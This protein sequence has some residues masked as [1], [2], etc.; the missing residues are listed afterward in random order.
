MINSPDNGPTQGYS[1]EDKEKGGNGFVPI[2]LQYTEYTATDARETSLAGDRRTTD[3]LNRSYKGKTVIVNNSS[4]LKLVLDTRAA[5]KD[6]PVIVIIRMSNPTVVRE[7][8][9]EIDA[10]LIN[11]DVQDQAIMVLSR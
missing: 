7:F 11:F 1:K 9:K 2:S 4:D 10:L 6:K 5:M 8:E 3:V